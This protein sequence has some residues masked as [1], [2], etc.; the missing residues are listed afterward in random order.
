MKFLSISLVVVAVVLG[1]CVHSMRQVEVAT[2]GAEVMPFDLD[3]TTHIFEK[4]DNGGLQQVIVD[5][6]GDTEQIALIRQHLAEEAE[7]FA[8]GNFHD[9]SMIHG[10]AMPGLHELVMGAAKIHIEYSEIAEGGQILYTTDDTELVD[11]IH[12]WFD[13]QVSDHGAHA[14]DHR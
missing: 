1:G 12:A 4:L 13:A 6:P 10:E 2:Q 11:A 9:P 3:K 14:A 5:E 8:Q 7:R